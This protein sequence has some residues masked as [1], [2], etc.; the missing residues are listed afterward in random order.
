MQI[1]CNNKVHL[2]WVKGHSGI[3]GNEIA[4][5]AANHGHKNDRSELFPLTHTENL[6]IIKEKFNIYWAEYWEN[7]SD[8]TG[9]GQFLFNLR[10]GT[11][12]KNPIIFNAL[13]RREQVLLQRIRIGHAGVPSY[14]ARFNIIQDEMCL[15]CGRSPGTL[16]HFF[17][18]CD[19]FEEERY[20]LEHGILQ[21]G[22]NTFDIKTLFIGNDYPCN[23]SI[24][25]LVLEFIKQ[26]NMH[27]TL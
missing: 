8:M 17:L 21:L 6:S 15:N 10:T 24:V 9:K 1:N 23:L 2:H 11:I 26:T 14:L 19:A 20:N 25:K 4:D 7:T 13:N 22:I 3:D 16:E 18:E 5:K 27:N 12:K